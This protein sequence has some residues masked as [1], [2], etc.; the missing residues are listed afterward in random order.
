M[1]SGVD[2][3]GGEPMT[4]NRF[5]RWGLAL[6]AAGA[7]VLAGQA[8]RNAKQGPKAMDITPYKLE[9][10]AFWARPTR[11]SDRLATRLVGQYAGVLVDAPRRVPVDQ[12][13]TLPAGIYYM[14]PVRELAMV[15]FERFGVITAMDVTHNRLYAVAGHALQR[16]SDP[17][18]GPPPDPSKLSAKANMSDTKSVDLREL[19]RVPWEP[20]RWLFM[21]LLRDRVSN[22]AEIELVRS[23]ASFVDPEVEKYREAERAKV[24]AGFIFP[25][26]GG[27][28]AGY[29]RQPESPAVPEQPGIALS[30]ARL[31]DQDR[32]TRWMV[33]GAF[34]LAPLVE[35]TVK[36]GW[37]DPYYA[38]RTAD[39]KPVAVVGVTL[40]LTGANDGSLYLYPLRVPAFTRAGA[41]VTGYFAL[42][43][44]QMEGAPRRAQTYFVYAF[45]GEQMAGPA[46]SA[47]VP[48]K[49]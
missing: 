13:T 23:P 39:P 8:P 32:E 10:E 49:E 17:V 12:R 45:A 28:L 29:K 15:P 4:A 41:E 26:P 5:G 37:Q 36:P 35:E 20:A 3:P 25:R 22:R 11:G 46:P 34:R 40:L 21:A 1:I 38:L 7:A 9:D 27:T 43:L 42:D 19:L 30:P 24:N 33:Y 18:P 14:G 16:D 44:R 48:R 2:G 47:L 6:A 31:V